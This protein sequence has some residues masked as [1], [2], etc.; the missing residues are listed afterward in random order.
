MVGWYYRLMEVSLSKLQEMVK[1]REASRAAVHGVTESDTTERLNNNYK[2]KYVSFPATA[3]GPIAVS[4]VP[5]V[6]T[7]LS[8]GPAY[9]RGL[10]WTPPWVLCSGTQH[11]CL[12]RSCITLLSALSSCGHLPVC[13]C[14]CISVPISP[15]D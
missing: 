3:S 12:T 6:P 8:P 2:L 14:A 1:D 4:S 15:S 9:G 10:L 13:L 5:S 11:H 7:T